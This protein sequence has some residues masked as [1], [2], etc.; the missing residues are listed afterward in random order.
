MNEQK[1]YKEIE[2]IKIKDN[3]N[4]E[5]NIAGALKNYAFNKFSP[6]D[7]KCTLNQYYKFLEILEKAEILINERVR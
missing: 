3:S 2:K 5:R 7:L 4:K 6:M 1:R